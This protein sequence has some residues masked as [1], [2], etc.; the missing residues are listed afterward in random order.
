[1]VITQTEKQLGELRDFMRRQLTAV[2]ARTSTPAVTPPVD[3]QPLVKLLH[4]IPLVHRATAEYR[5]V[6][7]LVVSVVLDKEDPD[8]W[9]EVV[10]LISDFHV[11]HVDR[12]SVDPQ[13]EILQHH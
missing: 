7:D 11:E 9:G 8:V 3:P 6:G 13:I 12:I 1:M 4:E 2:F 10:K 5:A